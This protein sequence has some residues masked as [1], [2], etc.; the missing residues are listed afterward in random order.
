MWFWF[1]P[2][3]GAY[4]NKLPHQ[5]HI[6]K[7]IW[8]YTIQS[9]LTLNFFHGLICVTIIV[10]IIEVTSCEIDS[11]NSIMAIIII[12]VFAP[13]VHFVVSFIELTLEFKSSGWY[14]STGQSW[15]DFEMSFLAIL[16]NKNRF[17]CIGSA[18][19]SLIIGISNWSEVSHVINS[20]SSARDKIES[21]LSINAAINE[22]VVKTIN[23]M[24]YKW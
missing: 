6:V 10:P 7:N 14:L 13:V 4:V 15:S 23:R 19:L 17:L 21:M 2:K 24:S 12:C 9:S 1:V 16:I 8:S 5:Y 18:A 22:N 20:G 3:P 11:T